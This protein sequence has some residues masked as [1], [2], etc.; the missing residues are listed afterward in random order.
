MKLI[1]YMSQ[2]TPLFEAVKLGHTVVTRNRREAKV[3]TLQQSVQGPR[4]SARAY[5]EGAV[6]HYV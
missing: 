6:V 5:G 1:T 2:V 3:E 4:P